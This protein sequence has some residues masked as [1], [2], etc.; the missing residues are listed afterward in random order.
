MVFLLTVACACGIV[1]L[2]C[3]LLPK[4]DAG[5]VVIEILDK[6]T[7]AEMQAHSERIRSSAVLERVIKNLNAAQSPRGRDEVRDSLQ[8][9]LDVRVS[10][11]FLTVTLYEKNQSPAEF[12]HG[13]A[14]AYEEDL[15]RETETGA[16]L[17]MQMLASQIT[18]NEA[19]TE[20]ARL[21][22]LD[23]MKKHDLRPDA[24][25]VVAEVAEKETA[26]RL[27]GARADLA[28][29]EAG[30][31]LKDADDPGLAAMKSETAALTGQ[32]GALE[33]AAKEQHVELLSRL[34]RRSDMDYARDR[35]DSQLRLLSNLREE[36]ANRTIR[37]NVVLRPTRIVE[38]ART[39]EVPDRRLVKFVRLGTAGSAVLLAALLLTALATRLCRRA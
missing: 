10:G 13:V 34:Q 3:G 37:A 1:A 35:Y 16:K 5:R 7:K 25:S 36:Y 14:Q 22:W 11:P 38:E 21:E 17:V 12:A 32:I 18:I 19:S 24:G 23:I 29:M 4:E 30:M 39:V 20:K 31:K 9:N 27:A 28:A 6:P 2:R 15:K 8:G 33:N 26:T